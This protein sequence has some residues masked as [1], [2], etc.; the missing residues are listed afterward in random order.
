MYTTENILSWSIIKGKLQAVLLR[1]FQSVTSPEGL[2]KTTEEVFRL[3]RMV[4]GKV[5]IDFYNAK[6]E[7][8]PTDT[9]TLDLD[10]IPLVIGQISHSLLKNIDGY[11]IAL[12]NL[13]SSDLNYAMKSNFTFYTEQFD[14]IA[15]FTALRQAIAKP[16]DDNI[17]DPDQQGSESEQLMAAMKQI[18]VGVAKGRR[19]SKGLERPQ[20]IS[21]D[22]GPLEASMLKQDK[23]RKEI[24]ELANLNVSSLE[25]R[26]ESAEA[27]KFNERT[28][29]SGLSY[30]GM[31]LQYIERRV[32]YYW[33][34]YEGVP[35]ETT[36][37]YPRDYSLKTD[38]HRAEE[39]D[40]MRERG[41][42]ISSIQYQKT[43]AKE[44]V[45]LELGN[46][47]T[48]AELETILKE[49]DASI[50][51]FCDA[52]VISTDIESRVVSA[53][54]ASKVRL[55]PAGEGAKAMKEHAERAASV[56]DAQEKKVKEGPAK[57]GVPD[58]DPDPKPIPEPAPK[59]DE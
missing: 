56:I 48:S 12:L 58:L 23:M 49:I 15:E 35:P 29:E 30:I 14:P 2:T 54:T 44:V 9:V 41:T 55:Y 57:R 3:A 19:Y 59:G 50:V 32:A 22:S 18:Q 4:E 39:A 46:R 21:P 52:D 11:Q 42:S 31:E 17:T 10:E 38:A 40:G 36:I 25:P 8:K 47:I 1:E 51:P 13:A 20:F 28:L 43:I 16:D 37:K 45:R 24:R 34:L 6:G 7:L 27:K 26:R 33:S 5:Q 53:D